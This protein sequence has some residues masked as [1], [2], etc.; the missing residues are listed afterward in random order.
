MSDTVRLRFVEG[1][2]FTS[3]LIEMRENTARP[4]TPSHV[5]IVV[6]G[7]YLGAVSP[8]GVKIRPVGY[9]KGTYSQ[10]FFVDVPASP[11]SNAMTWAKG[12]IG[13]Q[14]DWAAIF[15]FVLPVDL[16]IPGDYICSAFASTFLQHAGTFAG[17]L[18]V[19]FYL[20]SPRDLLL[21]VS[22]LVKTD[23]GSISIAT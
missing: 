16:H 11:T 7:G 5:E 2:E 14:Y 1:M 23:A 9:D 21:V 12:K 20:I 10:E 6:P 15:D 13:A 22:A 18:A 17:P 4:L 19:P 3:Q 8:D